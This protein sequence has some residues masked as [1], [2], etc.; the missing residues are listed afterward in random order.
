MTSMYDTSV[1]VTTLLYSDILWYTLLR[2]DLLYS[3][4]LWSTLLWS[5]LLYLVAGKTYVI[6]RIQAIFRGRVKRLG[7]KFRLAK[8]KRTILRWRILLSRRPFLRLGIYVKIIQRICRR[9]F[10]RTLQILSCITIQRTFRGMLGRRTRNVLRTLV[11]I[12]CANRIKECYER[13]RKMKIWNCVVTRRCEA[14]RT[15]QV[16]SICE[17]WNSCCRLVIE[18]RELLYLFVCMYDCHHSMT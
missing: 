4:L 15:I 10:H 16:I 2:S 7:Y 5:T 12:L 18:G 14:A 9:M 1:V 6:S 17:V 8:S 3:T 13:Y 11:R